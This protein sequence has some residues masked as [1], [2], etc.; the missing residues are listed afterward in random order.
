MTLCVRGLVEGWATSESIAAWAKLIMIVISG[1]DPS[2]QCIAGKLLSVADRPVPS[3]LIEVELIV[4]DQSGV[5]TRVR[6]TQLPA[7][8]GRDPKSAVHLTD[9]WVSRLHCVLNELDGT[10]VV[11][12]LGS[13]HGVFVNGHRVYDSHVLPGDRITLGQ[14]RVAVQYQCNARPA[15]RPTRPLGP[16]S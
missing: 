3:N 5:E 12:D 7:V 4:R 15:D 10:L 9:P 2:S 14:T 1:T 16:R 6:V 11:C 13:K 8:L